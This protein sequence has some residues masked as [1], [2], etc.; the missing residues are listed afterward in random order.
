MLLRLFS[1]SSLILLLL[2]AIVFAQKPVR[3]LVQGFA[4]V[5]IDTVDRADDVAASP[6][7]YAAAAT[8]AAVPVL[9]STTIHVAGAAAVHTPPRSIL[10]I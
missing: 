9:H 3:L 5:V 1:R 4:S 6:V 7:V 8:A 10:R 2:C